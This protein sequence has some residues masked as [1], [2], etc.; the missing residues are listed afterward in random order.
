[1]P[2]TTSIAW[3]IHYGTIFKHSPRFKPEI[4]ESSALY[5]LSFQKV[6]SGDQLWHQLKGY[7]TQSISI[8][9]ADFG[10][11]AL[12]G[13][14]IGLLP[15]LSFQKGRKK[16]QFQ[17]KLG[18][19][20]AFLSKKYHPIENPIN[21]V[22]STTINNMTS[23]GF[24]GLYQIHPKWQA[25]FGGSLTHFS[26]GNYQS[27]NLGINLVASNV[28]LAY[29]LKVGSQNPPLLEVP[30]RTKK[31]WIQWQVGAGLHENY[32]TGGIKSFVYLSSLSVL[33]KTNWK[34][35]F[36]LGVEG[37]YLPALYHFIVNNQVLPDQFHLNATRIIVYI[38][39]EFNFGRLAISL[40]HG[41]Y[42]KQPAFEPGFS[43][44]KSLL[45][46]GGFKYYLSNPNQR[47]QFYAGLTINARLITAQYVEWALGWQF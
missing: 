34:G 1:M 23:V 25:S 8:I 29:H 19:G 2:N 4:S 3:R 11:S 46:K 9:Y 28:G 39:Y 36:S 32:K 40:N 41:T 30:Q 47:H 22:I 35:H 7:P 13:Q 45:S 14:G 15:A 16:W 44:S 38:G 31:W 27:P 17:F 5:E 21:N 37:V 10:N 24:Q 26:N 20:L 43:L 18:V 42:L 12:F 6:V 33:R